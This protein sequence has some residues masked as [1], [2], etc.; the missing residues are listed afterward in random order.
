VNDEI[1]YNNLSVLK[2]S[3]SGSFGPSQQ[4][5]PPTASDLPFPI[6]PH[7]A[8][9]ASGQAPVAWV[10]YEPDAGNQVQASIGPK[11]AFTGH[12]MGDARLLKWRL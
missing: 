4:V 1:N 8:V 12:H 2:R 3:A 10:L 7:I 11:A 6:N 9:N 5:L